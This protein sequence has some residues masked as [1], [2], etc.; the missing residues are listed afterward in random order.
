MT[1]LAVEASGPFT[2]VQDLGRHG[3]AHL[4]V[5]R[6][7]AADRASLRLANRLVGNPEGNAGLEVLGGGLRLTAMGDAVVAVTGARCPVHVDGRPQGPEVSLQLRAG[8]SLRLGTVTAGVRVYVS[9]RGGLD[10]PEVL[11]SR[12]YDQLGDFGPMPLRA[13]D[14]LAIGDAAAGPACW[15]PVPVPA[16]ASSVTLRVLAGPRVD[17][18]TGGVASLTRATWRVADT[19][20]RSGLRLIGPSLDRR[21]GELAS[22]GLLPGAVQVPA[23]GQPILLGPDAGVTGGYPVVAVVLDADLDLAGQLAPGA[24]LRF[25][26]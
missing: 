17:W 20:N 15:E 4:G 23:D 13:G 3:L 8:D 7:G 18:L 21:V 19:S 22:E 25:R 14:L 16:P 1:A 26:T 10:V 6:S 12:S 9:V 11:G 5:P 24:T 2:T